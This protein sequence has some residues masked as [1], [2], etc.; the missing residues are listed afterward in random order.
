MCG[1]PCEGRRAH[2]SIDARPIVARAHAEQ[3]GAPP[4]AWRDAPCVRSMCAH[5]CL[6]QGAW[7]RLMEPSAHC[8]QDSRACNAL[9]ALL[10]QP[11]TLLAGSPA[12]GCS[13]P[14]QAWLPLGSAADRPVPPAWPHALWP[15]PS[16]Y[17]AA[18]RYRL[19]GAHSQPACM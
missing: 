6:H 15:A 10:H 2:A 5:Q 13:P 14:H 1:K 7:P 11:A 16:S 9:C 8:R 3:G 18:R 19:A 12:C 4:P 17:A